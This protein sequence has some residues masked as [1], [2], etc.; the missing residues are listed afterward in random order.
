MPRWVRALRYRLMIWHSRGWFSPFCW[1]CR[2]LRAA[3][4]DGE[5]YDHD[6]PRWYLRECL[7]RRVQ[8][9]TVPQAG[10]WATGPAQTWEWTP[11]H[12]ARRVS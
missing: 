1:D 2:W 9:V 6:V 7:A 8:A 3:Q 4:R 11:E 5:F 10:T 12:G